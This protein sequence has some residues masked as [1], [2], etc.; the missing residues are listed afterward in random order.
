[1]TFRYVEGRPAAP[2]DFAAAVERWSALPS[3]PDA[4]FDREEVI[5][6]ASLA[7]QVTWGTNPGQVAPITSRVPVPEDYDDPVEREAT[8][9]ALEYMGL[10]GGEAME[11]IAVDTV[12][13]G[14]CTN[15]RIEDLR[16]AAGIIRGRRVADGV[17]AMW[18]RAPCR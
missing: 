1:M 16:T 11:D 9:R 17:R 6:A 7:P 4:V 10:R 13:L 8:R 15:G 5:D 14:S 18:C 12:F 3:D 2:A